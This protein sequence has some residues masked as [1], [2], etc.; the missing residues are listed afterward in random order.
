MQNTVCACI[1]HFENLTHSSKAISSQSVTMVCSD[2]P[3]RVFPHVSMY[4]TISAITKGHR[5][6]VPGSMGEG[7]RGS[8]EKT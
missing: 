2:E 5:Q 8:E 7:R 4:I 1:V 6:Q 3:Y